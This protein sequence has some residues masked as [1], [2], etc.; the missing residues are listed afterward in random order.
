[1]IKASR[2]HI[3]RHQSNDVRTRHDLRPLAE[4][5]RK[6]E[7]RAGWKDCLKCNCKER[8]NL[9]QRRRRNGEM[10]VWNATARRDQIFN[11]GEE[12]MVKWGIWGLLRH[13]Q[14]PGRIEVVK[15]AS[16]LKNPLIIIPLTPDTFL[17][18][19]S[20][21]K[22]L[23]VSASTQE[24]SSQGKTNSFKTFP[25]CP[26]FLPVKCELWTICL[27]VSAYPE[28]QV[29]FVCEDFLV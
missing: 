5:R 20:T 17:W 4:V 3:G 23:A 16:L 22:S 25:L 19:S 8:S 2:F 14:L 1:M 9:Q 21:L 24:H 11:R 6:Q 7:K 12:E 29:V 15:N 27:L 18:A 10:I 28:T 26:A 13:Q